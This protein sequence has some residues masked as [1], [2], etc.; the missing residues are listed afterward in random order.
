LIGAPP[1]WLGAYSTFAE[2]LR[3]DGYRTGSI[4]TR[5]TAAIL[6]DASVLVLPEPNNRYSPEEI[7]AIQDF[8]RD[9]GGVFLIADH[10]SS[11]RDN[12]GIDSVGV[13][14]ELARDAFHIWFNTDY[15]DP[16]AILVPAEAAIINAPGR[17]VEKFGI[18][19]GCSI[20]PGTL[21]RAILTWNDHQGQR[22]LMAVSRYGKGKIF[23]LGD[24]APFG[25]NTGNPRPNGQ[26][27]SRHNNINE[28]GYGI[29]NLALNVVAW[30]ATP[31]TEDVGELGPFQPTAGFAYFTEPTDVPFGDRSAPAAPG[32][33]ETASAGEGGGTKVGDE[34]MVTIQDL[35]RQGDGIARINGKVTFVPGTKVGDQVRIRITDVRDRINRGEVI[36]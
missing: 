16:K 30:L 6:A 11:D 15:V 22:A 21:A 23:A 12:D 24:S 31:S 20:A 3:N 27:K 28:A 19:A 26:P 34:V 9:G 25:D 13:L 14:N 1:D 32:G 36:P 5:I 8:V 2:L 7:K 35:G 17:L 29:G 10:I 18:W 33:G 4:E